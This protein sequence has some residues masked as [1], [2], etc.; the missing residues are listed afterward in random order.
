MESKRLGFCQHFAAHEVRDLHA[1]NSSMGQLLD[2]LAADYKAEKPA[3][4]EIIDAYKSSLEE[5]SLK[6]VRLEE[7]LSAFRGDD[8]PP[9]GVAEAGESA[10]PV[11]RARGRRSA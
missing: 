11:R 2:K 7:E 10:I 9:E 4:M 3:L 6:R 1:V 5:N 8:V